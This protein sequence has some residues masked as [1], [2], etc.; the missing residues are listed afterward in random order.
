MKT[1]INQRRS[2]GRLAQPKIEAQENPEP[3]EQT[4]SSTTDA[5]HSKPEIPEPEPKITQE[6]PELPE[7]PMVE[8]EKDS[9]DSSK[10]KPVEKDALLK[11]VNESQ[12]NQVNDW[13]NA[14]S[15]IVSTSFDK[16]CI[17]KYH[18]ENTVWR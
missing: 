9:F 2:V 13:L 15:Q 11:P 10:W 6:E 1:L 17:F 12:V 18:F 5:D 8:P 16:N 3:Q 7:K 4:I 14:H